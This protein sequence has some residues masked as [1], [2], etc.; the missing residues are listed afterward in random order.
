MEEAVAYIRY[1]SHAQDDGNSVA[2]QINCI[3]EYARTHNFQIIHYYIDTARTGRNTNR[4]EYRRLINDISA[5]LLRSKVLIVRAID[6]LHR[7]AKN[8]LTDIDVLQKHQIRLIGITD[9]IDTYNDNY[10]RFATTIKL[11]AAEDYSNLLS[12][13]TKAA[14]LE[15][16]KK[17][18]H[19]GG[20]APLGYDVSPEGYYEINGSEAAIIREIYRLY[21]HDIGYSGILAYLE[22]KNYK[23]KN[24]RPFSKSALNAILTN[25]KYC[26]TYTY[27]RTMPKDD[28]GK[29]NSHAIKESYIRIPN[30]MPAI[31]EEADFNKVQEKMQ[32]NATKQTNR[33]GKQY[34]ALTGNVYCGQ[35]GKPFSGNINY[36]NGRKYLQYRRTCTCRNKS[37]RME[38]LNYAVFYA[39][40]NCIFSPENKAAILQKT[41]EKLAVLRSIQTEEIISLNNKI[42]GLR[43]AQDRLTKYLEEDKGTKTIL[44]KMEKNEIEMAALQSQLDQKKNLVPII[45]NVAYDKLVSHF[46][47][48]MCN[49]KSPEAV[50]LKNAAINRITIDETVEVTFQPGVSINDDTISYFND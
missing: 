7:N 13:N 44:S 16:A 4:P 41:K 30:G 6:R 48:Y 45:D 22:K 49:T 24:G 25:P 15:C 37:V 17:C 5:G 21:L 39:L 1:S 40:Q 12:K 11:A 8:G 18:K 3:D 43:D 10:S 46:I 33:N 34:Y 28:E 31:I 32:I 38:Q 2:A 9:G 26:G 47:S 42:N 14:L 50:D 29:R 36:S 35:C 27:D 19:L 20:T 23:T